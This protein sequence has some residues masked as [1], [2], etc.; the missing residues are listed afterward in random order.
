VIVTSYLTE[1]AAPDDK[2]NA[3]HAAVG[4]AVAAA[5]GG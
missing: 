1:T 4:C 5:F 3:A 2:R